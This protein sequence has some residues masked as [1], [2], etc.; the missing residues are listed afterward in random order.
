MRALGSAIIAACAD[1]D[2]VQG[3]MLVL[4]ALVVGLLVAWPRSPEVANGS[5]YALAGLR[6]GAFALWGAVV[7]ARDGGGD[8][9]RRLPMLAAL[10]A[11]TLLTLPLEWAAYVASAP[12]APFA[13][14]AWISVA[15]VLAAYGFGAAVAASAR[16]VR[17]G[18]VMPLLLIVALVG[19][20]FLDV[21]F[22]TG[23]ITPWTVARAPDAAP[24]VVL[25]SASLLTL[26]A[27][28]RAWRRASAP[29][30]VAA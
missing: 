18:S 15:F 1:L 20:G 7:G 13:W 25:G 22:Q 8:P 5:W 27:C 16:A 23:W 11:F 30:E 3:A 9:A 2:T 14:S 24:A 29:G 26:G 21:R 19:V 17:L 28:L 10:V 12:A 6:A 4:G